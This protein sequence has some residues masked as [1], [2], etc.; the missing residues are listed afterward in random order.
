MN[1]AIAATL[2]SAIRSMTNRG[3]QQ[4]GSASNSRAFGAR[5][6][7]TRGATVIRL[8]SRSSI[9]N[10]RRSRLLSSTGSRRKILTLKAVSQ[11]AFRSS[12]PQLMAGLREGFE[13][14]HESE[15]RL[16]SMM[17]AAIDQAIAGGQEKDLES[18]AITLFLKARDDVE[19][20]SFHDEIF[21]GYLYAA[22]T[23]VCRRRLNLRR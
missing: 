13:M 21:G 19:L 9:A 18:A 4:S 10:G 16:D 23:D 14:R 2:G 7:S 22:A 1:S 3:Q 5:P 12:P 6:M 17:D 8:G 11:P 15:N 20:A